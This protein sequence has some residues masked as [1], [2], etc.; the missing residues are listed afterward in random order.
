MP[1]V[2]VRLELMDLPEANLGSA[3][4]ATIWGCHDAAEPFRL[5]VKASYR[6]AFESRGR[7]VDDA[8]GTSYYIPQD[9]IPGPSVSRGATDC[10]PRDRARDILQNP[11]C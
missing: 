2:V 11:L 5:E 10:G 4:G 3:K 9:S 6:A 1:A 7:R 8:A